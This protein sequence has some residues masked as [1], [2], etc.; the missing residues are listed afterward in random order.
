MGDM[1]DFALEQVQNSEDRRFLYRMGY[2][3]IHDAYDE[4]I[5]DETGREYSQTRGT[6][7]NGITCRHCLQSGFKWTL[8][9][10]GWRLHKGSAL[11]NCPKFA[12]RK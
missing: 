2:I 9:K 4:G 6:V 10:V 5:V 1:A 7:K 11:H 8:T 3:N 12:K